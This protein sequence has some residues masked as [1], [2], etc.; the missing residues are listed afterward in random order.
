MHAPLTNHRTLIRQL[1][2]AIVAALPIVCCD[3]AEARGR[4][5]CRHNWRSSLVLCASSS[6]PTCAPKQATY[7]R[8]FNAGIG[9][10]ANTSGCFSLMTD[11]TLWRAQ[12]IALRWLIQTSQVF[13]R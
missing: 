8:C 7:S 5:R 12:V 2:V 13:A 1:V 3:N 10:N 4:F 6:A 9:T 11:G